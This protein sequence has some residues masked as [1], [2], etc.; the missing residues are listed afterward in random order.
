M[1]VYL[2][3]VNGMIQRCFSPRDLNALRSR[4]RLTVPDADTPAELAAAWPRYACDA[5]VVITS[6]HTP[7][8][9]GAMLDQ[10]PRLKLIL[11]AAGSVRH[12]LPPD[13]WGRGIRLATSND[14]LAI[15]VAESTLGMIIAGMK[16]FFAANAFTHAGGWKTDDFGAAGVS[17]R[18][19]Y[20][21]TVGIIGASK[22]GRH[23]IRLIHAALDD[24]EI[25][26]TDPHVD[27]AEAAALGVEA[28]PLDELMRRSDV[29][30]LHAPALPSTR[31]M[32]GR[33]QFRSMRDRAIFINTARGS[34]VDEAA[35][36]DELRT[37]RIW[38]FIDVTQ[39]EPP[40]LDHP[41]RT[42]PNVVLTPHIA[43]A[44]ANGVRR[45][46]RSAVE[47]YVAYTAGEALV[48]ELVE[49][50]AAIVA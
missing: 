46:G 48:G 17:M 31:G 45:L 39:D 35:L 32:L 36:A 5:D 27:A 29:V 1:N 7:P 11:H 34:I 47:Q 42:L 2:F 37:G 23:V 38:A 16:G 50:R 20:G 33:E 14:A 18:D 3:M 9:T 49:S 4:C 10:A 44:V 28:V 8:L 22:V 21:S 12:L 6:W 30:S 43:G 26:L 15:G 40:P 25:L 13:F 19:L 41:F 24:V